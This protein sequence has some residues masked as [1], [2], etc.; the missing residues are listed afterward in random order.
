M[1]ESSVDN[2]AHQLY[3]LSP[4]E[5]RASRNEAAAA[6]RKEGRREEAEQVKALG[7]P[8]AAAWALNRVAREN[9]R[10]LAAFVKAAAALRDAQFGGRGDLKAATAKQR[11]ALGALLAAAEAVLGE[12]ASRENLGR[13]RQ[14]L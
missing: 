12:S 11:A 9:A 1:A 7:K 4:D 13:I 10:E 14:S 3:G 5:F 6:L 2:L 8:N